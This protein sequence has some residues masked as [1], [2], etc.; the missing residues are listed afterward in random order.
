MAHESTKPVSILRRRQVEE[1]IGIKSSAL[2]EKL[3]PKSPTY[4]PN[5]PKPIALGDA[6]NS[7]VGWIA[8]ELDAWIQ[9]RIEISRKA[10]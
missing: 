8:S 5:F 9:L 2:Y 10:A 4:D 3:N 1:K 7:P 6:K